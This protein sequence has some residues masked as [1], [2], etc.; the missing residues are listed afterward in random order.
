MTITPLD[1]IVFALYLIAVPDR[2]VALHEGYRFLGF[3]AQM[4][5]LWAHDL[6]PSLQKKPKGCR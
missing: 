6:W 4:E 5:Q 1:R 3:T 2:V